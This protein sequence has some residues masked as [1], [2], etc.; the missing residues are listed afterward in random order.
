[1]QKSVRTAI[2]PVAG[3]GAR[4]LPASSTLE[5]CMM[6]LYL[7]EGAVPIIDFMV[8]DCALAGLERVIFV[9]T[10]HGEQELDR[11]FSSDVNDTLRKLFETTGNNDKLK[12]ELDRRSRYSLQFEYVTQRTDKYGTTVP[13]HEVREAIADEEHF[14]LIGGDD[15]VYHQDGKS[16][17]D[18]A[19]KTW[20]ARNTDHLVMGVPVSREGAANTYGVLVQDADGNFVGI[21]EKPP[22]ERVPDN[23]LANISRYLL[24]TAVWE[25]IDAEMVTDRDKE[26][27]K[28]T[29]PLNSAQ[30]SGQTFGIHTV[31][32]VYLDGGETGSMLDA[33]LYVRENPPI[34]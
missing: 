30:E 14:A 9:T 10:K 32:G 28:I 13:L 26:E 31:E 1:M 22:L 24:N 15:F 21:D 2:I 17:L 5:K 19:I 33:I 11:Y 29:Y 6:P 20:N 18:L 7:E 23:P 4:L 12:Q 25:H 8:A 3:T 16:E 34:K 27:H